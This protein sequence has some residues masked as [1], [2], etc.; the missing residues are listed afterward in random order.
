MEEDTYIEPEESDAFNIP[1]EKNKETNYTTLDISLFVAEVARYGVPDRPAS[2][3]LNAA[4]KCLQNNKCIKNEDDDEKTIVEKLT[5]DSYKIRRAKE[6]FAR[7]Q[8]AKKT[9]KTNDGIQFLV[10]MENVIKEL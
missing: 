6:K 10:Q 7:K 3:L 4:V 1:T 8:K 9:E 2:A 5:V